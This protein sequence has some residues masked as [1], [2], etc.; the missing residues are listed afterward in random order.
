[1]IKPHCMS[2]IAVFQDED[3]LQNIFLL[4]LALIVTTNVVDAEEIV[5]IVPP[6]APE[7]HSDSQLLHASVEENAIARTRIQRFTDNTGPAIQQEQPTAGAQTRIHR[8]SANDTA[9]KVGPKEDILPEFAK[10]DQSKFV[11]RPDK[12]YDLESESNSRELMIAW[13]LWHKQLAK[14]MYERSKFVS[15]GYCAYTL[16]VAKNNHLTISILKAAGSPTVE[17]QIVAVAHSLNGNP[18]LTFPQGSRRQVV[19]D[20][21]T[22]TVGHNIRSGYDWEH[23]DVENI[24]QTW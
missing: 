7:S 18:G 2:H 21:L 23:G 9:N 10:V 11:M 13:E 20:S 17:Q 8:A 22:V 14:A 5:P 19:Q 16:T 15:G 24:H 3:A 6:A 12:P 4:V 1:M